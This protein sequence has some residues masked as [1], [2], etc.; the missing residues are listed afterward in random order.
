MA[1]TKDSPH[2]LAIQAHDLKSVL[3]DL[4]AFIARLVKAAGGEPGA[5]ADAEKL[6]ADALSGPPDGRWVKI[7]ED[8]LA[9]ISKVL[10]NWQ[11]KPGAA[12]K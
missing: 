7:T 3:V 4:Q 10:G 11:P 1:Q 9:I 2:V 12:K 6:L 5:L 8:V